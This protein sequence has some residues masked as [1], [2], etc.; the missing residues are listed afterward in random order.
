MRH[1]L[2][3]T[4]ILNLVKVLRSGFDFKSNLT[5]AIGNF[6][7]SQLLASYVSR[8][9]AMAYDSKVVV[10]RSYSLHKG[11]LDNARRRRRCAL[12]HKV[13]PT[14]GHAQITKDKVESLYPT[15]WQA[16]AIPA[17]END[18]NTWPCTTVVNVRQMLFGCSKLGAMVWPSLIT[19]AALLL[20]PYD[21]NLL[22]TRAS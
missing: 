5:C 21:N 16:F 11:T 8:H 15:I 10:I 9:K 3:L 14:P 2:P 1:I 17:N 7:E 13:R 20:R 22:S 4:W 18:K 12:L 6:S 19:L